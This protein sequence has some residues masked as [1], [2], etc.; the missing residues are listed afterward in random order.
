MIGDYRIY[1]DMDAMDIMDCLS[2]S[3]GLQFAYECYNYLGVSQQQ[4]FIENLGAEEIVEYLDEE[5][6]EYLDDKAMI[7][8]LE[9]RGY[10]I[11]QNG[12]EDI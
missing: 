9:G 7:K 11:T 6:V 3:A 4:K 2:E 8:E 12:G 1:C 5:I 10:K